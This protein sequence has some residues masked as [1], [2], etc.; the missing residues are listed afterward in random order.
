MKRFLSGFFFPDLQENLIKS[1]EAYQAEFPYQPLLLI[2]PESLLLSHLRKTITKHKKALANIYFF[3]LQDFAQNIVLANQNQDALSFAPQALEKAFLSDIAQK[4]LGQDSY[5]FPIVRKKGFL[6]SLYE[7]I[8]ELKLHGISSQDFLYA[9]SWQK[10]RKI[11]DIAAIFSSYEKKTRKARLYDTQDILRLATDLVEQDETYSSFGLY[12]YGFLQLYP[13]EKRFL[14]ACMKDRESVVF[15]PCCDL[16]VYRSV[17]KL[18]E[19]L[20]SLGFEKMATE[21]V[22]FSLPP[23]LQSIRNNAPPSELSSG[24][25]HGF[26][27]LSC[28]NSYSE[29]Q[30]IAQK[31][32]LECEQGH[33]VDSIGIFLAR[34]DSYL[35]SLKDTFVSSQIP[36]RSSIDKLAHT[37]QARLLLKIL[38]LFANESLK[39]SVLSIAQ[40]PCLNRNF[41]QETGITHFSPCDW[42]QIALELD[43]KGSWDIWEKKL[44]K[45]IVLCLEENSARMPEEKENPFASYQDTF[46][47]RLALLK[48]FL[49]FVQF[50]RSSFMLIKRQNSYA[51]ILHEIFLLYDKVCQPS[52]IKEKI[53]QALAPVVQIDRMDIAIDLCF[54]SEIFV[55]LMESTVC[56]CDDGVFLCDLESGMGIPFSIV[57]L[58]GLAEKEFPP[59]AKPASLLSEREKK[60]L[61]QFWEQEGI[62]PG[63]YVDRF[64]SPR[65]LYHLTLSSALQKI[66]LFFPRMDISSNQEKM[67]STFLLE[68]ASNL[69]G[70]S[71][72][73]SQ[74][75]KSPLV[76]HISGDILDGEE[77][78]SPLFY[79]LYIFKIGE[80]A[81][82][83]SL[84]KRYPFVERSQKNR[85][86]Q[87]TQKRFTIFDGVLNN[88]ICSEILKKKY[89][90]F[91]FPVEAKV[92][93]I[94][95]LCPFRFFMKYILRMPAFYEP[96][97]IARISQ[98]E[99]KRLISDVFAHYYQ[100]VEERETPSSL[101]ESVKFVFSR[102][103]KEKEELLWEV[104]EER[105]L[106]NLEYYLETQVEKEN[107]A[108]P[109]ELQIGYGKE[110]I[111]FCMLELQDNR[112]LSFKGYFDQIN[113]NRN[114]MLVEGLH[115]FSGK[116]SVL[117][118][119]DSFYKGEALHLAIDIIALKALYP[120]FSSLKSIERYLG[121]KGIVAQTSFSSESLDTQKTILQKICQNIVT[122]I[123]NGF[124]F[125]FPSREKC[126]YCPYLDACGPLRTQIYDSRQDDPRIA[127]FHEIK[128]T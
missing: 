16:P 48:S 17:Q 94:Y 32:F 10:S 113:Q 102:R 116:P 6:N 3:T 118:K 81:G 58:P 69:S 13:L 1:I 85:R 111:S 50:W 24:Q 54:L 106:E 35:A 34:P 107:G 46:S 26:E 115:Y 20:V 128:S 15:I 52:Q 122:G 82:W 23:L 74:F 12:L 57:I 126:M 5:F 25:Q 59:P 61:N 120:E 109:V 108:V 63:L 90:L 66:F 76:K 123:E 2:A 117:P 67:P 43:L 93:E 28:L 42:S 73:F 114:T 27:I 7:T 44:E 39:E 71:L 8:K 30:S 127:F 87:W 18:Q 21:P 97:S 40:S 79:D 110:E 70:T 105:T 36:F 41:F 33:A 100:D 60:S 72:S 51:E 75:W 55:S 62:F 83:D 45:E 64:L 19:W 47:S 88:D 98:W 84:C 78:L 65:L 14:E 101:K 38:E 86:L 92:L 53:R 49:L 68:T 103:E 9:S 37:A 29:V 104:E 89:S 11:N 77:M 112:K 4:E 22:R 99:Q 125:P 124:F 119:P 91:R 56:S 31:I 95:S 121:T 96:A 80:K